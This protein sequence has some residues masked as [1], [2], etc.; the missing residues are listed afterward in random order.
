M[1]PISFPKLTLPDP[2]SSALEILK[3]SLQANGLSLHPRTP[4]RDRCL[5]TL[6]RAEVAHRHRPGIENVCRGVRMSMEG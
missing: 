6:H 1:K 2:G 5:V 4:G 3:E